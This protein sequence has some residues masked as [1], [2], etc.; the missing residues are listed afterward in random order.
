MHDDADHASS[1]ARARGTLPRIRNRGADAPGLAEAHFKFRFCVERQRQIASTVDYFVSIA[2][3]LLT[4]V[5]R[6]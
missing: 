5:G 3:F 1:R 2:E 6:E 4:R